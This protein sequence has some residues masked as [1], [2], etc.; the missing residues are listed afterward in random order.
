MSASN[1]PTNAEMPCKSIDEAAFGII[2]GSIAVMGGL[3]AT[4]PNEIKPLPTIAM[5]LITVLAIETTKDVA[6]LA[7][8]RMDAVFDLDLGSGASSMTHQRTAVSPH[9]LSAQSG[10]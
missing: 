8:N 4:S 6:S 3:S 9:P 2:Y 10:N 1:I 7:G 5:L